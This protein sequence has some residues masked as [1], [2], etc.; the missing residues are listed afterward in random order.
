MLNSKSEYSR[1]KLPRLTIYRDTW[2]SQKQAKSSIESGA[3]KEMEKLSRELEENLSK[4]ETRAF[5]M[6]GKR[7]KKKSGGSK[8]K[9]LR[10]DPVVGWGEGEVGQEDQ[11]I[12]DWLIRKDSTDIGR[13][14]TIIFL[15]H[16]HYQL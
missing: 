1:C 5:L 9:R 14:I 10:L 12:Q 15:E 13:K 3:E 2:N 7:R 6:D 8:R 4:P 16:Q 11:E